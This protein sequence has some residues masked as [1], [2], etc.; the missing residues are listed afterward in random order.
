M[1]FYLLLGTSIFFYVSGTTIGY[2][3]SQGWGLPLLLY[4]FSH[5]SILHLAGN[6]YFF[7][8]F[9]DVICTWGSTHTLWIFVL[10]GAIAGVGHGVMTSLPDSTLVG[11]SGAIA[12]II[13]AEA[14]Y[15]PHVGRIVLIPFPIPVVLLPT[16]IFCIIF[17]GLDLL[18]VLAFE[19]GVGYWAHIFGALTGAAIAV[20]DLYFFGVGY[21]D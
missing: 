20:I 11:A 15:R 7:Y 13:A 21:E 9:R 5:A 18:R 8:M 14:V 6:F 10:L 2:I 1:A 17:V 4:S 16:W 3:P 19:G 12:G